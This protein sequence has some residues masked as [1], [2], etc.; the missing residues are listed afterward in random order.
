MPELPS[1]TVTLLFTDVEGSTRLLLADRDGYAT[2]LAAHRRVIREAVDVNGGVEVDTQGDAVF[3]AFARAGD[4]VRAATRA[5]EELAGGPVRVRMGVHTGAPALTGEGYAGLDV[6]RAAR[7]AAA[8]HGGQILLSD[9]TRALVG[10]AEVVDLGAHRLRDIPA[11]ERIYQLGAGAFPPLRTLAHAHLP[12]PPTPLVGRER[13]LRDVT[14]RLGSADVRLLTLTGP[15]GTGKTRLALHAAGAVAEGYPDGVWWVALASLRDPRLVPDAI[16]QT[17]G[18]KRAL[19]EHIGDGRV[20]LVLDNFEQVL[21]AGPGVAELLAA[22]PA[23]DV[24][25]TSREPLHVAAEC[26]HR[27]DPLADAEAVALFTQRARAAQR[28]V[29]LGDAVGE[30]CRRL[31]RL[32][33]AL[34]LAAARVKVLEPAALLERLRLHLPVL[35]TGGGDVPERQRTL[36]AAIAWSYDL[37]SPG[38]GRQ[39]ARLSVFAGGAT[40]D[41]AEAICEADLDTLASLVDKSLLRRTGERY[42]M[43]ETIREFA[44]ERLAASGEADTL[45]ARHADWFAALGQRAQPHL[46]ARTAQLWTERLAAEHA[47]LRAALAWALEQPGGDLAWRL[48][49]AVWRVWFTRGRWSEGARWLGAT[50]AR[51]LPADATLAIEPLWGAALIAIWVDDLETATARTGELR[52][53]AERL[54]DTRG[55]AAAAQLAG[56][57]A[58]AVDDTARA[59]ALGEES[60]ALARAAGDRWLV[61]TSVNNVGDA[62]MN[63]GDLAG[64]AERFAE[65]LAIAREDGEPYRI[66]LA[67]TNLGEIALEEGD[68][69]RAL[70]LAVEALEVSRDAAILDQTAGALLVIALALVPADPERGVRVLAAA[71]AALRA[72]G[73]FHQN[74]ERMVRERGLAQ[75][76][77]RLGADRFDAAYAAGETL[78]VDAAVAEALAG[79]QS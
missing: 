42:W 72:A 50:L 66:T 49:G 36:S 25:V 52:E 41:A 55:R 30:I 5:Q 74:F 62:L 3:A 48:T 71:D 68:G 2:L 29:E 26:E 56:I 1:G 64:A 45:R 57:L 40:L 20:L 44:A 10:D 6:H 24:L 16:A 53:L 65:S 27:I 58:A 11:P 59:R 13:E 18:A 35:G 77:E 28:D 7:I 4:A 63:D 46:R 21:T 69:E 23:L 14:G 70:A 22:C 12:V 38:E 61:S 31:D 33:L 19:E 8:G 75:A 67:L 37:L 78:S 15:G 39:F 54:G 43:L 32:P 47:N 17:V 60:I 79:R 76:R 51:P 34:E 73:G 9:A